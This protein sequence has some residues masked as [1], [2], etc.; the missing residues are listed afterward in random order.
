MGGAPLVAL[1]IAAF[2][3][4]L[5]TATVAAVFAAADAQVRAAGAVL[6]GGH[7]LK[8]EEP[9]Y[10]L[11][12][13][14]TADPARLWPKNGARPGDTLFLTKPLGTGLALA[15]HKRGLVGDEQLREA[16]AWMRTL[17]RG[18]AEALRP[19]EPNAVTDVTGFGLFGHA[20]EVADRSGVRLALDA[21][22]FPAMAGALEAAQAGVETRGAGSNREH[23]HDSLEL[24]DV[25]APFAALAFDPQTAG[26]LLLSL[27]AARGDAL[28]EAFATAGLFLRRIGSVESG[29]GIA[30][31]A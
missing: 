29:S 24:D 3:E 2:P 18:A 21:A 22:S 14:G 10:G 11:A 4:S 25:P 5:P 23:V 19:F 28:E 8:D 1:S 17:N 30:V 27:P 6:A 16:V 26:G 31:R 7:T 9:K 20:H 15:A 13:V 12:V